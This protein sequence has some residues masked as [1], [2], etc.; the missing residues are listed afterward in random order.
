MVVRR[1]STPKREQ[2]VL[3]LVTSGAYVYVRVMDSLLAG[4]PPGDLWYKVQ[5]EVPDGTGQ[6][7]THLADGPSVEHAMNL[8]LTS[9]GKGGGEPGWWAWNPEHPAGSAPPVRR[10][11][12]RRLAT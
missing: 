2:P 1:I 6:C 3:D 10:V 7:R 9:A 11:V 8:A 12:K 4:Q 5:I